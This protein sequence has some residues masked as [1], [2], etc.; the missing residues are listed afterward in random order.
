VSS[1]NTTKAAM[2]ANHARAELADATPA[3]GVPEA[4]VDAWTLDELDGFGEL[5]SLRSA[6]TGG[7]D[8]DN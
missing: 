4:P 3:I 2:R 8:S 1:T 6:W 5:H 7:G